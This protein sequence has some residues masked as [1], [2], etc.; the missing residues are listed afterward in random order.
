MV[1]QSC[2]LGTQKAEAEGLLWVWGQP[3]LYALQVIQD[4]IL[5][6]GLETKQNKSSSVGKVLFLKTWVPEFN[7]SELVY[8]KVNMVTFMDDLR[9][10]EGETGRSLGL[11]DKSLYPQNQKKSHRQREWEESKHSNEEGLACQACVCEMRRWSLWLKIIEAIFQV[12]YKCSS[13]TDLSNSPSLYFML[14][15]F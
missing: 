15:C 2:N 4:Y 3:G 1:A 11:I 9:A 8:D 13:L 12:I 10:G 6:C 5:R 14:S 7:S